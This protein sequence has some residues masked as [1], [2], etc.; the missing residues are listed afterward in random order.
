MESAAVL[1]DEVD[2]RIGSRQGGPQG[3]AG[4]DQPD[5]GVDRQGAVRGRK[6]KESQHPMHGLDC[7]GVGGPAEVRLYQPLPGNTLEP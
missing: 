4:C 2:S 1:I 5:R 3:D 7:I 6:P